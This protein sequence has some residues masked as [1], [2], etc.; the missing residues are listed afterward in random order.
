MFSTD[1]KK[2]KKNSTF[3]ETNFNTVFYELREAASMMWKVISF[4]FWHFV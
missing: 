4:I 1:K 3:L 2:N